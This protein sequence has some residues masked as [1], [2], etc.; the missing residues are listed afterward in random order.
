MKINKNFYKDW[1]D[2]LRDILINHWGYD[3]D[4]VNDIDDQELPVRYFNAEQ[5]RI[6]PVKRTIE[7]SDVFYCPPELNDGWESLKNSIEKGSDLSKNLSKLVALIDETDSM[8]N[9]WKIHH[10]HLG[11]EVIDGYVKR[12]G[13]LIFAYVTS[14]T[15][16]V[17][18]I[19]SHG[20]W[21]NTDIIETI[22]RNWPDLISLS[23]I[24]GVIQTVNEPTIQER[25]QLRKVNANAFVT[26]SDGTVYAPLG[27]G[28][29]ANGYNIHSVMSSMKQKDFL[30]QLE[31]I[32]EQNIT[33]IISQL[34]NFGY[35]GLSDLNVKLVIEHND[36]Y[37]FF[38]EFNSTIQFEI[39]A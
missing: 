30:F 21:T 29:T 36:Y 27:G 1:I 25:K 37:A 16:Y 9:D 19:F 35:D 12:T 20:Q 3:K 15:V 24:Q 17:V 5:R 7:Y 26:V 11:T 28:S 8:L 23:R 18:N 32:L 33:P 22:H 13:P 4:E 14:N 39:N 31:A 38:E 2:I 34:V 6:E 10:F